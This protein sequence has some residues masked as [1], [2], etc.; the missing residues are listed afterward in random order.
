MLGQAVQKLPPN[1]KEAWSLHTVRQTLDR[2]TLI[3]FNDWLK[4]K[5]EAHESMK[6]LPNKAKPGE[7]TNVTVT[8][9]KTASYVFAAST[10]SQQSASDKIM[11]DKPPNTCVACKDKHPLCRCPAFRIKTPTERAKIVA[12]NKLRFSCFN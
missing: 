6:S 8:K 10:S 4:D 11:N 1:M 2:P 3:D 5:A 12:D 7:S 9:T